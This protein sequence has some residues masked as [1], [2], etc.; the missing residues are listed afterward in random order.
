MSP[1][2]PVILAAN[3]DEFY[4][5][6][7][8]PPVALAPGIV[9]G[10]DL[11]SGG[12]WLALRTDGAFA[13]VTNQRSFGGRDPVRRTRGELPLALLAGEAREMPRIAAAIDAAA[14]NAG[15]LIFGSAEAIWV[16]YLRPD[17]GPRGTVEVVALGPG[18]HVLANDRLESPE[19]PRAEHLAASWPASDQPWPALAAALG[20][21]LGDHARPPDDRIPL[22][23]PCAPY[24]HEFLASLQQICI[25]T[26]MY[27]TR[28]STIAGLVPGAVA[29]YLYADGSPCTT[30]FVDVALDALVR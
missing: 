4:A 25:H 13:A 9:G 12:T 6:P 28:S 2:L 18:L 7:A 17:D 30:P 23:P 20:R 5:R 27:G 21:L 26:P 1:A 22:P 14:Y 24:G 10:R 16:A 15:N 8:T 3:R 11:T 19:F 29:H